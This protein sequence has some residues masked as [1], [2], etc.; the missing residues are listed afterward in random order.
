VFRPNRLFFALWPDASMQARMAEAGHGLIALL[1]PGGRTQPRENLH[2]TLLFLGDAIPPEIELQ[3][4]FA[5]RQVQ[6]EPFS[7]RLDEASC[8]KKPSIWW[9][10]CRKAPEA[11][12]D[13]RREIQ[14][15][16]DDI[17]VTPDR[18][19]FHPHITLV[20]DARRPLPPKAI[21]PIEWS[22][23]HFSLMRSHLGEAGSRYEEIERW[24]LRRDRPVQ[25]SLW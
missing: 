2:L 13:L 7:V 23:S 6:S 3:V 9:L 18:K 5:A 21:T 14:A 11:L 20:R 24:P 4:R 19:H 10:G 22:V 1:Q 12:V 16:L 15:S 8:F 17:T 25:T